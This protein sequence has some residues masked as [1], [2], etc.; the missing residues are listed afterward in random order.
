[1]VIDRW[2]GVEGGIE[3]HGDLTGYE[4]LRKIVLYS[5]ILKAEREG[6]EDVVLNTPYNKAP[7]YRHSEMVK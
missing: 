3:I 6:A 7:V 1:V 4:R 5:V 2:G